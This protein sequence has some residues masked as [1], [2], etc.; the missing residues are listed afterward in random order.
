MRRGRS[1]EGRPYPPSFPYD[2]FTDLTDD[3][4]GHLWAYLRSV[5]PV[6]V[7]APAHDVKRRAT[8]RFWLGL[9]R[10]LYFDRGP[11]AADP[12]QTAADNRGA[13]LGEAVGHCGG[14]HTPR[15]RYGAR[16]DNK[17]LEGSDGEP[18]P[19]PPLVGLGWDADDWQ[20]FLETGTTS[21]GDVVGGEMWRIIEDGTAQLSPDDRAALA[22]WLARVTGDRD[23]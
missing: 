12:D 9:W 4:L 23:R 5:P 16:I 20:W 13:Y 14:C 17:A 1:P 3:D 11:F 2:Q 21:E 18:E 7:P 6:A 10:R 22:G 19:A 15:N 8:S